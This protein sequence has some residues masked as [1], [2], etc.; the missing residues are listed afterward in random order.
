MHDRE[1]ILPVLLG[2]SLGG[3]MVVDQVLAYP[4]N[5]EKCS[6]RPGAVGSIGTPAPLLWLAQDL[7]RVWPTFTLQ[8]GLDL[9]GL[10]RDPDVVRAVLDARSSIATARPAWQR[11]CLVPS[12]RYSVVPRPCRA[13]C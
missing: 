11:K 3:L 5:R 4:K 13:R 9:S 6:Q 2:H 1:G 12:I 7:S 10:A 8:T